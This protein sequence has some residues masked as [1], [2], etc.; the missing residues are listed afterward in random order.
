MVNEKVLS[1]CTLIKVGMGVP[2][3]IWAVRALNSLQ[4]SIDLTPLDPNAGPIGGVGAAFPAGTSNLIVD[5]ATILGRDVIVGEGVV[6]RNCV[7][8]P[9]KSINSDVSNEVIM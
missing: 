7:V 2:A 4:K 5:A 9:N 1:G 8:L 6:V 3:S